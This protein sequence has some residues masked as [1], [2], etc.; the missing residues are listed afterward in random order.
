M[1][2]TA[3]GSVALEHAARI[4]FDQGNLVEA[5]L[6]EQAASLRGLIRIA[7]PMSFG[8]S[9]LAPALP[10]FLARLPVTWHIEYSRTNW[11]I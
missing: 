7:A 3:S 2:L 11:L 8:L 10:P 9:Q 1:A 4:L 6:S 5:T